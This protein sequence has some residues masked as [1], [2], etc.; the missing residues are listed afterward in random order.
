MRDEIYLQAMELRL[1]FIVRSGGPLSGSGHSD[2]Y[3]EEFGISYK[4]TIQSRRCRWLASRSQGKSV[5]LSH[6]E[7]PILK[8]LLRLRSHQVAKQWKMKLPNFR[9][10]VVAVD[11]SW[12]V[13]A[14]VSSLSFTIFPQAWLIAFEVWSSPAIHSSIKTSGVISRPG[15]S[16]CHANDLLRFPT[17]RSRSG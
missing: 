11:S 10:Y 9:Q 4:S 7:K 16:Q 8:R 15:R 17:H 14:S 6:A 1:E 2:S 5:R 13:T 12:L 3:G